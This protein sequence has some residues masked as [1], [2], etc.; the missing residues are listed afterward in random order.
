MLVNPFTNT[1]QPTL[2][3]N[4][5]AL[6][7]YYPTFLVT[8]SNL[9][10]VLL[11]EPTLHREIDVPCLKGRVDTAEL[12]AINSDFTDLVINKDFK[13]QLI[14]DHRTIKLYI[15]PNESQAFRNLREQ[16]LL[17]SHS[18]H[19]MH[20]LL[21]TIDSQL[22]KF[23]A[24]HFLDKRPLTVPSGVTLNLGGTIGG[25]H[26]IKD[27]IETLI[28]LM[29]TSFKLRLLSEALAER[30]QKT[31]LPN[32]GMIKFFSYA[33]PGT[34]TNNPA[35][36]P[37]LKTNALPLARLIRGGLDRHTKKANPDLLVGKK[38]SLDIL[39]EKVAACKYP[40]SL[41]HMKD[42]SISIRISPK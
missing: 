36:F 28:E 35:Y 23:I 25:V 10:D 27:G 42:N 1:Y 3:W 15:V 32:T 33:N 19:L 29:P 37:D 41:V 9:P 31:G 2:A 14:I 7:A 17:D 20:L 18:D 34:N 40:I 4:T 39:S 11:A 24:A 8:S 6:T 13:L 30:S 22:Q 12:A 16:C 5:D 38:T 21:E 26:A